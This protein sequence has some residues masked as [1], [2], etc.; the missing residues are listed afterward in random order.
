MKCCTAF[1][2][3]DLRLG[4]E[5]PV[6]TLLGCRRSSGALL[7]GGELV[8]GLKVGWKLGRVCG[9]KLGSKL[10]ESGQP[11]HA[12]FISNEVPEKFRESGRLAGRCHVIRKDVT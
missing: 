7:T 9:C 6:G 5:L 10:L 12:Q 1:Y 4:P 2:Y 8:D 3:R 11:G